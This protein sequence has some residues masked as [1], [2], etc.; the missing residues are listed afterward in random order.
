LLEVAF[1]AACPTV[2]SLVSDP[3]NDF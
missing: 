2:K 1:R 3:T